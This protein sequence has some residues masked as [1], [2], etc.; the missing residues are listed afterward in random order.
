MTRTGAARGGDAD[1]DRRPGGAW[2]MALSSR[3]RMTRPSAAALPRDRRRSGRRRARGDTRAAAA[4]GGERLDGLVGDL[5]EV[6]RL[7][8]EV[9]AAG[10]DAG[11]QEEVVDERDERLDVALHRAQVAVG[12]GRHAVGEGLDGG[13][14]R[15]D[16][17]AQV[18]AD[19]RQHRRALGLEARPL[20]LERVEPGGQLVER[21]G[22]VA[23]LVGAV[24]AG[25]DVAVARLDPPHGGLQARGVA[26]ER[27]R[28]RRTSTVANTAVM[29]STPTTVPS[30]AASRTISRASDGRRGRRAPGRRG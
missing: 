15:G 28:G 8:L 12:V 5:G 24:D 19:A 22:D 20:V 27:R 2:R 3:L 21:P 26:A 9:E 30:S 1:V 29:A 14:Q 11:Q 7:A 16:R 13:P 23:E 18:V 4:T 6:D 25:A 17:R 10:L